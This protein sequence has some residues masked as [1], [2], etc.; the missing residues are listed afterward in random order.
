[1]ADEWRV[2]PPKLS[3]ANLSPDRLRN[4]LRMIF[5][6]FSNGTL[7][8]TYRF[9]DEKDTYAIEVQYSDGKIR[10][11]ND[12]HYGVYPADASQEEFEELYRYI[13]RLQES[14]GTDIGRTHL[15]AFREM[16]AQRACEAAARDNISAIETAKKLD[17]KLIESVDRLILTLENSVAVHEKHTN[18][19][20]AR[21]HRLKRRANGIGVR[22]KKIKY[23]GDAL[24]YKD[25]QMEY[26]NALELYLAE[27][28]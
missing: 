3:D 15:E 8:K 5:E 1:M 23:N 27:L 25:A 21:V 4:D 20:T 18:K 24:A 13:A 19:P 14:T 17:E 28:K 11:F 6:E 7:P 22:C 26:A 12:F 9:C 10:R 16:A 2:F